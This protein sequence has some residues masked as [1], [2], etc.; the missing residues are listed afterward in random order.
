MR[1]RS[2]KHEKFPN[3]GYSYTILANSYYPCIND[4]NITTPDLLMIKIRLYSTMYAYDK[5]K[6]Y[7]VLPIDRL[8][9]SLKIH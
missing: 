6:Q 5:L 8:H 3:S 4:I 7:T 1:C 9:I 2:T